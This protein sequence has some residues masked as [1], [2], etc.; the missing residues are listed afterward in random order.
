[1]P[2]FINVLRIFIYCLRLANE[3]DRNLLCFLFFG[4]VGG[5]LFS[6][7]PFELWD[8]VDAQ[9]CVGFVLDEGGEPHVFNV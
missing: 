6:Y 9:V 3:V 4:F 1:M 5:D 8:E 7:F 2:Y